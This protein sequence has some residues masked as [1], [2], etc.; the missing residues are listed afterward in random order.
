MNYLQLCQKAHSLC[1]LQ[2]TFSSVTTTTLYQQTLA[3]FIAEAWYDI[4]DLRRDWPFLRASVSFSTVAGQSEYTL[5]NI[6]ATDIARWI[7]M[8]YY[9]D[10]SGGI[11][12]L[13]YMNYDTYILDAMSSKSQS[14][15]DTYA[16]DPVDKHLY[17]NVPDAV[18][19][20]TG[21]YITTPTVLAAN[22]D[23]PLLPVAFHNLIAYQGAAQMC[24]FLSNANMY[25]ILI[26]KAD[27]MM[28]SLMRSE[29]PSR[30]MQVRGIC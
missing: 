29:L 17:T 3:K 8:I 26:Q 10:A 9:T 5:T 20:V 27:S 21:H 30:K 24:A 1:G 4:Q 16:V 18:Y 12:E 28:G 23:I 6:G 11:H 14:T 22:T 25:N 13:G 19:T 7:D 2:G 15:L